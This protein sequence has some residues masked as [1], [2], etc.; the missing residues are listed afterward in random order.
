[1]KVVKVC[2]D[3][4]SYE[5]REKERRRVS[6]WAQCWNRE[7]VK[8]IY[9]SQSYGAKEL[10]VERVTSATMT[11]IISDCWWRDDDDDNVK[12]K[13]IN[14]SKSK[15]THMRVHYPAG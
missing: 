11:M 3:H 1:M 15:H 4:L 2:D 12:E 5:W 8:F 9:V 13:E 10:N 14:K 7:W 6:M